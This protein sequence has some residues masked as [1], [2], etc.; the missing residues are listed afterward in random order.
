[1]SPP[2]R[3]AVL[4]DG[5]S[6]HFR[7]QCLGHMGWRGAMIGTWAPP[8]DR[9]PFPVAS[10]VLAREVSFPGPGCWSG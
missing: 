4:A 3:W 9:T 1:M 8:S 6:Q 10:R 2:T 7:I 5:G